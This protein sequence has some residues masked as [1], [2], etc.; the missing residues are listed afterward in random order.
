VAWDGKRSSPLKLSEAEIVLADFGE[1][2]VP[3]TSTT[4]RYHPNSADYYSPPEVFF[5]CL[6]SHRSFPS[7]I[8]ALACTIWE[9]IAERSL[10]DECWT[11]AD[12]VTVDPLVSYRRWHKWDARPILDNTAMN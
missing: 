7:D 5:F 3:S 4:S 6:R 12:E 2:F 1:S 8:W 10:F 9:I 11:I